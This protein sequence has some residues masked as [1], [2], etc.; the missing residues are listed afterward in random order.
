[1]L[2]TMLWLPV[3]F[4]LLFGMV[5]LAR[6]SYT[7]YTLHKMLYQ[8][9]RDVGTRQALD[10]CNDTSTAITDAKTFALQG[11]IDNTGANIVPNLDATQIDVSFEGRDATSGDLTE[12][13]PECGGPFP[14]PEPQFVVV[15]IPDGYVMRLVFYGFNI[16]PFPLRPVVRIPFGGTS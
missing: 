15:S 2:E 10:F 5:E 14:G 7:Y 11:G 9:A 1:M 13:Q 16:D 4:S 6:V 3:L 12:F 8:I